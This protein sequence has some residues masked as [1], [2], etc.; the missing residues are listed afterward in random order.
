MSSAYTAKI[1][2]LFFYL[3]AFS[4]SILLI[5]NSYFQRKLI[6]ERENCQ[7]QSFRALHT[8][9]PCQQPHGRHH[10]S[11]L[12]LCNPWPEE[13]CLR[14]RRWG[15][16]VNFF[17][18]IYTSNFQCY[19][20]WLL[21]AVCAHLFSRNWEAW[22]SLQTL[23]NAN[24]F[25]VVKFCQIHACNPKGYQV[26]GFTIHFLF[27]C[28]V[29]STK[30]ILHQKLLYHINLCFSPVLRWTLKKQY[31]QVNFVACE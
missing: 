29:P 3:L 15:K 12:P 9:W 23:S 25:I 18:Q 13:L 10:L 20:V 26:L 4:G 27:I 14:E 24:L 17:M 5:L 31:S 21:N 8:V 11:H 1:S 19:Q 7:V 16:V 22:H 6:F 28:N 30:K 2:S